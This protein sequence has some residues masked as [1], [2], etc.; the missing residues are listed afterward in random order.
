MTKPRRWLRYLLGSVIALFALTALAHTKVGLGMIAFVTGSDGCPFGGAQ[1]AMTVAAADQLRVDAI[2]THVTEAA[3]A[4]PALGF[5]LDATRRSDVVAWT[6]THALRCRTDRSGAGVTCRGVEGETLPSP[7]AGV[8]GVL[9]FGFDT[10]DR[11][12]SVSFQ[13]AS[14]TPKAR[15]LEVAGIAMAQLEQLGA[16]STGDALDARSFVRRE[17]RATYADY[18]ATVV[19]SN[20]GKRWVSIQTFQSIPKR[21]AG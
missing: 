8:H 13:T 17:T 1:P 20:A 16:T 3:P 2:R 6:L 10:A 11:L 21:G 18:T 9:A 12:V 19:A 15:A 4:R 7:I 14:T 5:V